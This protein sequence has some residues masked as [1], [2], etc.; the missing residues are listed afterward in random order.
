MDA[1]GLVKGKES[2]VDVNVR[3]GRVAEKIKNRN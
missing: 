1:K 3:V 2:V